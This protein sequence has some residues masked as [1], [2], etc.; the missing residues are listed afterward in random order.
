LKLLG[1]HPNPMKGT[2]VKDNYG[3]RFAPEECDF[4]DNYRA[5][6]QSAVDA[7]VANGL[8]ARTI[9]IKQALSILAVTHYVLN[10]CFL[11]GRLNKGQVLADLKHRIDHNRNRGNHLRFQIAP[12]PS[13]FNP[14]VN[15]CKAYNLDALEAAKQVRI[16]HP[17]IEMAYID[18]PYG[19]SQSDYATMFGFCEEYVHSKKLDQLDHI[20]SASKKFSQKKNYTEHFKEVLDTIRWIPTWS[21]SYNATSFKDIDGI[22]SIVGEYKSDIKIVEIAHKYKYRKERSS[23]I[24]YLIIAK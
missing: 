2:F 17:K 5:N 21:I 19:Q 20:E 9:E 13:F 10:R 4:L 15:G 14:D 1:S 7:M 6:V 23:A 22:K 18:P 11:G 16:N 12:L 24:E 8:P 3:H